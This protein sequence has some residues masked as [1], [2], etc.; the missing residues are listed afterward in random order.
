MNRDEVL[1]ALPC[2]EEFRAAPNYRKK[3]IVEN[4][5]GAILAQLAG[6]R[7]DPDRWEEEHIAK[8]IGYLLSDRYFAASAAAVK[9]LT[10]TGERADPETWARADDTATT[11]ALRNGLGYA[12]GKPARNG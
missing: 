7:R 1:S 5:I 4:L 8:A 6:E 2:E 9:A 3:E 12:A 11:S 10:P